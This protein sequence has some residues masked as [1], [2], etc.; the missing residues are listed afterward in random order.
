MI[1]THP[2]PHTSLKRNLT[3][4]CGDPT[5]DPTSSFHS[6]TTK[7][8]R[9]SRG[10]A[11]SANGSCPSRRTRR[12]CRA[13]AESLLRHAGADL[14]GDYTLGPFWRGVIYHLPKRVIRK[15]S[16]ISL[17]ARGGR[18]QSSWNLVPCRVL[19]RTE[20]ARIAL[21]P[22]Q[23]FGFKTFARFQE[24]QIQKR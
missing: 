21:I 20:F 15:S 19:V 12:S 2:D 24:V 4:Q 9:S 23:A 18:D 3:I 16:I 22:F 6:T 8:G 13:I 1:K 14:G 11:R 10:V 17:G 7:P 5:Q